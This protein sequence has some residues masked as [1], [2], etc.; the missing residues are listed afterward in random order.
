MT[1]GRF[2]K[3]ILILYILLDLFFTSFIFTNEVN[4]LGSIT[5]VPSMPKSGDKV[6]IK[7]DLPPG[8]TPIND[9]IIT[10]GID[11][12]LFFRKT[13]KEIPHNAIKSVKFIWMAQA[14]RHNA[15]FKLSPAGN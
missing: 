11:S 9:V 14:G 10:G 5:I 4:Y 7:A 12:E 2:W 13:F 6:V 15:W 8:A 3:V 1:K